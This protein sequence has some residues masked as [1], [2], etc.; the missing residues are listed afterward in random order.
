MSRPPSRIRPA[1]A[2][3]AE[4]VEAILRDLHAE[5]LFA[6]VSVSAP[7]LRGLVRACIAD[8]DKCC[9][10]DEQG[11]RVAGLIMGYSAPFFFSEERGVWD[12]AFY[13]RPERRGSRTALLLWQAFEAWAEGQGA[14]MLWLVSST[15]VRTAQTERFYAKLGLRRSGG[16]YV[17]AS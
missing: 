7:K 1:R 3:D 11:G 14:R 13:V 12:L 6:G 10:L 8:G 9:L 2:A 15:G 5:S 16:A 17:K 4:A